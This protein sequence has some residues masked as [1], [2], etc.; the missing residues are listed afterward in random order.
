MIWVKGDASKAMMRIDVFREARKA[1]MRNSKSDD[2]SDDLSDDLSDDPSDD[3][4]DDE[5]MIFS[6][7]QK[8]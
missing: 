3:F 4:S 5:A 2:I 6:Q 7:L 8:R 1:M